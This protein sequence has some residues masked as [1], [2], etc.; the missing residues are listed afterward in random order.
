MERKRKKIRGS[1]YQIPIDERLIP[2]IFLFSHVKGIARIFL[3]FEIV[4][5]SLVVLGTIILVVLKYMLI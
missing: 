2:D 1:T 3:L 4:L 5:S